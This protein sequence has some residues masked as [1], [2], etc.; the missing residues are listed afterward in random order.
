MIPKQ[1]TGWDWLWGA[2]LAFAA[3]WV[4]LPF[5]PLGVDAHHDGIMLKPALDVLSGQ[6]LFKETFSQYGAL[7]T[8]LQSLALAVD[9]RLL[10]LRLLTVAAYAGSLF[11][12]Y[13]AWR[14][15]LPRVLCA[16]AAGWYVIY[17]PF[18]DPYWHM[19]PWS[20]ALA[21]FFQCMALWVLVR[22]VS[23]EASPVWSWVL[24]VSCAGV[25]W[26]RQPV[27]LL[28][29]AAVAVI[30]AGL[31][32]RGWRPAGA[33]VGRVSLRVLAGFSA[34][35]A[36]MLARIIGQGAL[37]DWWYQNMLWPRH[38]AT[39]VD[40]SVFEVFS[41]KHLRAEEAIMLAGV[42]LLCVVPALMRRIKPQWPR[43]LDVV[44]IVTAGLV[45]YAGG[46]RTVRSCLLLPT[47][48]G[49]GAWTVI[50][51]ISLIV[52]AVGVLVRRKGDKD[53]NLQEGHLQLAMAGVALAS[54]G[55]LYPVPCMNHTFWS[56]APGL[57]LFFYLLW[58]WTD[59]NVKLCGLL[60]VMLAVPAAVNKYEMSRYAF[61]IN[62]V[63]LRSPAMLRG[64]RVEPAI[65]AAYE[66]LGEV[67]GRVLARDPE[68]GGILY[69]N[70]ALY[71]AFFNNRENPSPYYVEW[72]KLAPRG[73][74]Q[75]RLDY[76]LR[77]KPVMIF[78]QQE[79]EAVNRFMGVIAEVDY[80][81]VL[82]EPELSVWIALPVEEA[83]DL[84][85]ES[86]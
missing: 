48:A 72:L 33:T 60:L 81:V 18:Y 66:R 67:L 65:A 28:L 37:G 52:A 45:Y 11:F 6:A 53:G 30:A 79:P 1:T 57:G 31:Y 12:M 44:W 40:Q 85:N 10:S 62:S 7:T 27:G 21:L 46:Y 19:L 25:F 9:T 71:L 64:M 75:K 14:S 29:G 3:A 61:G 63:E 43:W 76:L 80:G 58:R 24:G 55:Q 38:W 78:N 2:V 17:A 47:G 51:L 50:I 83:A 74:R 20:S 86:R 23:G 35:S 4:F 36:L 22:I 41:K 13:L 5:A 49:G 82:H 39:M 56:V 69:G 77:E 59:L 32:W 54:F 26:C 68:R 15:L 34:V 16:V 84:K 42:V 70:D 8:Y 73:D